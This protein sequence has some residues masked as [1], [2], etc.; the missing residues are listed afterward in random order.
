MMRA[1][2]VGPY[3]ITEQADGRAT[4]STADGGGEVVVVVA[5]TYDEAQAEAAYLRDERE[6]NE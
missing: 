2:I 6:G 1:T 3:M 4:V 5:R